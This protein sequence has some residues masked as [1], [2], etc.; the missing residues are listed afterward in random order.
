MSDFDERFR[1]GA[2]FQCACKFRRG[3]DEFSSASLIDEC[4][5][6][7]ARTRETEADKNRIAALEAAVRKLDR[8]VV[9]LFREH[10][11]K[12][13]SDTEIPNVISAR[14]LL[15]DKEKT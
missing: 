13:P 3:S 5:Y 15:H 4:G 11:G 1:P 7:A 2:I 12:D 8:D 6:H 10:Y 14:A 9:W